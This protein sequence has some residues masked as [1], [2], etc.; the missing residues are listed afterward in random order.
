MHSMSAR[1][2]SFAIST[3]NDRDGRQSLYMD[4]RWSVKHASAHF[5]T[6]LGATLSSRPNS[7]LNICRSLCCEAAFGRGCSRS[8]SITRSLEAYSTARVARSVREKLGTIST[9]ATAPRSSQHASSTG[10]PRKCRMRFGGEIL[11]PT[12]LT[13]HCFNTSVPLNGITSLSTAGTTSTAARYVASRNRTAR[14]S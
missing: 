5:Y 12:V 3:L 9:A 10:R 7:S 1:G 8:R 6:D 4:C 11:K 2:P 14:P 13:Y